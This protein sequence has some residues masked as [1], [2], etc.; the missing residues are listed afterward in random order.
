VEADAEQAG[1]AEGIVVARPGQDVEWNGVLSTGMCITGHV[2]DERNA[3]VARCTIEA[4]PLRP[5]DREDGDYFRRTASD[6]QGRF[7]LVNLKDVPHV[8]LLTAPDVQGLWE[9]REDVRPGSN[10]LVFRVSSA[11]RP[12]VAI[13]GRVL[14]VDGEP[15]QNWSVEA[16]HADLGRCGSAKIDAKAGTFAIEQIPAGTY[17]LSVSGPDLPSFLTPPHP[18]AAKQTWDAGE[19]RFPASGSLT[20]HLR[21]QAGLPREE[22]SLRLISLDGSA[23][24]QQIEAQGDQVRWDHVAAGRYAVEVRGDGYARTR[25]RV[26]LTAGVDIDGQIV[27]QPGCRR[28]VRLI[29]DDEK[30][31]AWFTVREND[32]DGALITEYLLMFTE[33]TY[34]LPLWQLPGHY[35]LTATSKDGRSGSAA[36]DVSASGEDDVPVEM[37]LR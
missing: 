8:V 17:Q 1:K 14:G 6:E 28:T 30:L 3:P 5:E 33:R 2:L 35:V 19:I 37:I 26:H 21:R 25:S 20:L 32:P 31:P 9:T 12:S 36:V 18:I 13:K 27:L 24:Y 23:P 4:S 11:L 29:L 16:L 34:D 10:E 7:R 15:L 22:P